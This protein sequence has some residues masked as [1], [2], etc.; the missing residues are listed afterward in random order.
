MANCLLYLAR[1]LA[2]ETSNLT[3]SLTRLF[4]LLLLNNKEQLNFSLK[5]LVFDD[6]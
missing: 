4:I 5:L 3:V 1:R 6:V 2:E